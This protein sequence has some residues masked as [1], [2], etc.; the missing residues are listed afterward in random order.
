[1]S[2]T[3]R[4]AKCPYQKHNKNSQK[5]LFLAIFVFLDKFG[6]E[7]ILFLWKTMKKRKTFDIHTWTSYN[8]SI[9]IRESIPICRKHE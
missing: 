9:F 6:R 3:G 8:I 4:K 2:T 7:N 5:Q 1:M